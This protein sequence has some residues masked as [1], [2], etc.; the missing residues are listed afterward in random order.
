MKKIILW[1][2]DGVILDS[3]KI[4]D[5][6]FREIFRRYNPT[7]VEQFIRYHRENGGLS[8]Y[9]KIRYFFEEILVETIQ[10]D[11]VLDYA[12]KFSKLMKDKLTNRENLIPSTMQFIKKNHQ[13]LSFHIISASDQDELRYLAKCLDL[14]KYFIS[15]HGSPTPKETLI[16]DLLVENRYYN[17]EVCMIGDS[18][19]DYNAAK[20]NKISFFNFNNDKISHLGTQIIKFSDTFKG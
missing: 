16:A 2:F 20:Q 3:L 1:D 18:I 4:R 6:G 7:L 11:V 13:K 5:W 12:S 14:E 8:R 19:N 10:E 15:I 17:D 9:I